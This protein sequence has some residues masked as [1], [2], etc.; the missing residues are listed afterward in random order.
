MGECVS[1]LPRLSV[2]GLELFVATGGGAA[3]HPARARTLLL[4][5]PPPVTRVCLCGGEATH[6]L[7]M[8]A[9]LPSGRV[10]NGKPVYDKC[11]ALRTGDRVTMRGGVASWEGCPGERL[12]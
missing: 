12:V 9:Y 2:Y 3:P 6:P 4:P 1:A 8:G 11:A 10:L 5:P 7:E